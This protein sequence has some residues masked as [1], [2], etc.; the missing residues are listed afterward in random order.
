MILFVAAASPS[1]VE[2]FNPEGKLSDAK[3]FFGSDMSDLCGNVGAELTCAAKLVCEFT[4][5]HF[6]SGKDSGVDCEA[7]WDGFEECGAARAQDAERQ[8]QLLAGNENGREPAAEFEQT[9]GAFRFCDYGA[10][11]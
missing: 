7:D 2:K 8:V 3:N 5:F 1:I 6:F 4:I 9:I 10:G 11:F